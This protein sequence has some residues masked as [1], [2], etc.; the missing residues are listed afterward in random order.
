MLPKTKTLSTVFQGM[1]RII[2]VLLLLKVPSCSSFIVKASYRSLTYGS[3]PLY[4]VTNNVNYCSSHLSSP[5]VD[6]DMALFMATSPLVTSASSEGLDRQKQLDQ[7]GRELIPGCIVRLVKPMKAF[8]V[9]KSGKILE[10]KVF[11]P[12]PDNEPPGTRC[13]EL[14]L[15]LRGLVS[16]VYDVNNHDASQPIVVK[17]SPGLYCGEEGFDTPV[18]FTMHFESSEVEVVG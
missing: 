5:R 13:L 2:C 3:S 4:R 16:Q 12:S 1:F 9:Q 18:S 6:R 11:V 7:N 14:P 17:F 15:G 10:N 8:H